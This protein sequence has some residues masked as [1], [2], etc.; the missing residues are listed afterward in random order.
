[1]IT[2]SKEA[3]E[4]RDLKPE[5]PYLLFAVGVIGA[6]GAFELWV[7]H[8]P[9]VRYTATVLLVN[10]CAALLIS[11]IARFG[12]RAIPWTLYL[13][14]AGFFVVMSQYLFPQTLAATSLV[15]ALASFAIFLG[16]VPRLFTVRHKGANTGELTEDQAEVRTR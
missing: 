7:R 11:A 5:W 15:Q 13:S 14:M 9:D 16:L 12:W 3:T 10:G 2:L 8:V 4:P 6:A 1:M